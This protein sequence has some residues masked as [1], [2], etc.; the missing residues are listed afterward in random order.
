MTLAR[1][2]TTGALFLASALVVAAC[3][4]GDGLSVTTAAPVDAPTTTYTPPDTK[5]QT[6]DDTDDTAAPTGDPLGLLRSATV[7][8]GSQGT[9]IDPAFG[10]QY[11][12]AGVG[13]G[14]I[15]DPSGIAVTNNH[16]VTGAATLEV[17]LNDRDRTVNA[18]ILGVSEC[19]DLAVIDLDG[20]GY[21]Y[22][23]FGSPSS[24]IE[25]LEVYAAGYPLTNET[26]IRDVDYTLT[27]GIISSTRADGETNWASVDSVLEHDARIRGGNSGG[28]LTTPDARVVGINYSGIN[29]VDQNFAIGIDVA[30]PIIEQLRNG[31]D[32]DSLGINGQAVTDGEGLSG[33]WVASVKSG[34]PA[35]NAGVRAGDIITTLEGLILATDGTMSDYCDILRT[36]GP[37]AVLSIE[38]LRFSTEEV[39][40]GEI[41][42]KPLEQSFSFAQE[43]EDVAPS[44]S[45]NDGFYSE[46]TP[47][48]DD[49]GTVLVSVPVEWND[50]DGSPNPNFGPSIW[51]APDLGG[52][53]DTFDVPGVILEVSPD[54]GPEAIVDQ[55]DQFDFSGNCVNEGRSP[56]EDALYSGVFEVW[57]NCGGGDTLI[58]TLAVTPP[59]GSYLIRMLAQIVTERDLDALD[60]IFNTFIAFL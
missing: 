17:F 12:V 28:P 56:F 36:Q 2:R 26:S 19:S 49:T 1:K 59:D 47:V 27:R 37:D 40:E 11:N 21:P 33:I 22:L 10:A 16:V 3:G 34:S 43:I 23:E 4:G 57:A 60:Q 6:T 48:S 39:L 53:I 51:A 18:R 9:F 35:S 54:L 30:I 45:G 55:L 41:N 7:K 52:F 32:V 5:P 46:Y 14:F 24:I 25:G 8:I 42:G 38:V 29:E 31:I 13:T 50:T 20:D 58:I 15:I 44:G